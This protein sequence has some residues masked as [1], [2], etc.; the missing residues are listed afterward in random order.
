MQTVTGLSPTPDLEDPSHGHGNSHSAIL[1]HVAGGLGRSPHLPKE[2]GA[3]GRAAEPGSQC[4]LPH[5]SKPNPGTAY[6]HAVLATLATT[7]DSVRS[8]GIKGKV[9]DMRL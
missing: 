1:W 5:L 9:R 3:S 2:K 6:Q 4:P 7:E 8:C